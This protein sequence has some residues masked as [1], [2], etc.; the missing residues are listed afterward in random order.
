TEQDAVVL[1]TG[2]AITN[3]LEMQ[4]LRPHRPCW[5]LTTKLPLHD[6]SG[7]IE[8]LVGFSR[9]VRERF[10]LDTIPP[11]AAAALG[12]FEKHPGEPISASELAKRANLSTA[13]FS[14]LMKRLFNVTPTQ[15]ITK[16][17]IQLAVELLTQS[18]RTIAEI[19]LDSGY[20]DHSAFTRAFRAAMGLTPSQFRETTLADDDR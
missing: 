3:H 15:H 4:W 12:E 18:E 6:S 9:D 8:G 14:R 10:P 17:R 5:C 1:N 19:A 2:K 7:R 11:A 20:C 13:Q 16:M